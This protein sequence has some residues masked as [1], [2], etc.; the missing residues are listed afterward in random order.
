M[1]RTERNDDSP[2]SVE[3]RTT[4]TMSK[5]FGYALGPVTSGIVEYV[6]VDGI[7]QRIDVDALVAKID[8]N[9][10]IEKV[11]INKVLMKVDINKLLQKVDIN[12]LLQNVNM[13]ELAERAE[14]GAIV[15]RSTAGIISPLMDGMRSQLVVVD[16]AIQGVGTFRKP[17]I[18]QAPGLPE[19]RQHKLP[20]GASSIAI[21]VQGRYSGTISRG[22]AFLIDQ[23]IVTTTFAVV[24]FFIQQAVDIVLRNAYG[25]YQLNEL[26][27]LIFS[28]FV[29]WSFVYYTSAL[30]A[31]GRT[32]GK[33]IIGLKVINFEDGT[34]VTTWRAALRT[35]FLPI[36]VWGI[37]GVLL[38]VVRQ[39]RREMHDLISGTGVIYS[40]DAKFAKY[41]EQKIDQG[42]GLCSDLD[43]G[44]LTESTHSKRK[45]G[46]FRRKKIKK[47]V[48]HFDFD[49]DSSDTQLASGEKRN[50]KKSKPIS[51]V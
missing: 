37:F 41:R 11:D 26:P 19:D 27:W 22:L 50:K 8:M 6:D 45:F 47:T 5:A 28:V 17:G 39:D 13:N 51:E 34:S 15:A 49:D 36:S 21:A 32:I 7:V 18:P 42:D 46:L 35:M 23:L 29:L 33:T 44:D 25:T 48:K 38:G 1:G 43:C 40:W 10:L 2:P 12:A 14:I 20:K 31:T 30:A 16:Q 24:V 9:A 3:P 4:S